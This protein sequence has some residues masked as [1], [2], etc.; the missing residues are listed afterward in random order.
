LLEERVMSMQ[1]TGVIASTAEREREAWDDGARGNASRFTLFSSDITPTTAMSAGIMELPPNGGTLEPH[2][3]EQAE[4]YFVAE[5]T[6]VLTIDGVQ[7]TLTQGIAA[8]IAGNAEHSVR[9]ESADTL[10]I[11]YVFP[12]EC[13]ADIVYRFPIEET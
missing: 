3:H 9:N 7:T 10:K 11:F 8:F 5:G 4:I 2:R 12:T 13:F 1:P 6:G